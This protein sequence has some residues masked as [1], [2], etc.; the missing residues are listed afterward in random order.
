MSVFEIFEPSL[1]W[2]K[3]ARIGFYGPRQ[4]RRPMPPWVEFFA[5]IA[6][7]F[8]LGAFG[9]YQSLFW[10]PGGSPRALGRRFLGSRSWLLRALGFHVVFITIFGSKNGAREAPGT[11]KIKVFVR[12]VCKNLDFRIFNTDRQ[13]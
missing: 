11:L 8:L 4:H 6:P 9:S 3:S 10:G 1:A 7:K 13:K 5:K 2:P 12:T